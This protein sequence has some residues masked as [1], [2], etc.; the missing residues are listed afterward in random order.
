MSSVDFGNVLATTC[1]HVAS[2]FS[3]WNLSQTYGGPSLSI[4]HFLP[5]LTYLTLLGCILGDFYSSV[6][7]FPDSLSFYV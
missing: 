6:F 5:S 1:L 3:F 2:P 4:L 7:W